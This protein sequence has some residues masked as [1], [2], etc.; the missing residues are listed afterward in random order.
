[1]AF[2]III[3]YI[4]LIISHVEI[5]ICWECGLAILVPSVQMKTVKQGESVDKSGNWLVRVWCL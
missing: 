2:F 3:F 5:Q 4:L 1:M